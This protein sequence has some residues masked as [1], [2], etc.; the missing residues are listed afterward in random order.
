[1]S[2]R[3]PGVTAPT[4]RSALGKALGLSPA[5]TKALLRGERLP[6][7]TRKA[8]AEKLGVVPMTVYRLLA[9][10]GPYSGLHA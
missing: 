10:K 1:M 5:K 7:L 2:T 8:I 4:T 6:G 3:K 9:G